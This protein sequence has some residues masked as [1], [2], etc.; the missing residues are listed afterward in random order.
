[1]QRKRVYMTPT[2]LIEPWLGK[3]CWMMA[4]ESQQVDPGMPPRHDPVF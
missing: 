3:E 1:M 4:G 2:S